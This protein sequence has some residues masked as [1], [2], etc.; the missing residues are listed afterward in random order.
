MKLFGLVL[1]GLAE[2]IAIYHIIVFGILG[3]LVP[4]YTETESTLWISL[5]IVMPVSVLLGSIVTG[6]LGLPRIDKKWKLTVVAPGLYLWGLF[7]ILMSRST[8]VAGALILG[9]FWYLVS[10]AG[11]GLGYFLR[12]H[13]K[14]HQLFKKMNKK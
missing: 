1:L 9:F 13:I 8:I 4:G 14:R 3:T 6:Y 7:I 11:V 5:F 10:L 2:A 12:M